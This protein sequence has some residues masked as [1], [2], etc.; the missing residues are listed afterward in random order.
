MQSCCPGTA[1]FTSATLAR[2]AGLLCHL[3]VPQMKEP[4]ET[5]LYPVISHC[6]IG[7]DSSIAADLDD[8]VS[9]G[10]KL[11]ISLK[12]DTFKLFSENFIWQ[13]FKHM[14]KDK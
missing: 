2:A 10:P 13:S 7:W 8:Q 14:I 3:G 11:R 4:T 12:K 6:G 1:H 9:T 5:S